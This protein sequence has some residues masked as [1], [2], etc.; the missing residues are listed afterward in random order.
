MAGLAVASAFVSGAGAAHAVATGPAAAIGFGKSLLAG[1][2]STRPTTLQWGP[3]GRLYVLQ[4][5][6]TLCIYRVARNGANN[7]RVTATETVLLIKNI[8]NHDDDGTVNNTLG[9][10]QATG[11]IVVAPRRAP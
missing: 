7:Y 2:V 4:Q 6:G 3:D 1:E 9:M 8:P 10:R 5:D 11:M